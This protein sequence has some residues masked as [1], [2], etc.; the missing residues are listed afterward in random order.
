[1]LACVA[2][3]ALLALIV[4]ITQN[5]H[6][7]EVAFL[8]W[9]GHFPLVVVVLAAALIGSVLT[10]VLGTHPDPPAET[11]RPAFTS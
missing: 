9:H 7:V 5:L 10:L 8:G 1:M 3:V 11:D 6:P 4:F 2:P